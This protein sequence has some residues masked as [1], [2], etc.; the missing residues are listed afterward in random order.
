MSLKI[1]NKHIYYLIAVHACIF[2]FFF[3]LTFWINK[4][5]ADKLVAQGDFFQ[6]THNSENVSNYLFTWFKNSGQGIYNPL[7]VSYPY[8]LLQVGFDKLG[9]QPGQE[10]NLQMLLFLY[11]SFLS[12]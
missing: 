10:A 6:G 9:M 7:M 1:K 5:P 11:G 2:V 4:V 8:Y 3:I 12:F